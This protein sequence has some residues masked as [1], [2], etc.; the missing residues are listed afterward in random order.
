[1]RAVVEAGIDRFDSSGHTE[2]STQSVLG[3]QPKVFNDVGYVN[4]GNYST[5]TDALQNKN[6]NAYFNYTKDLGKFKI[7]A[8]A[9]YNYQLFQRER[10]QS[11]ETRQPNPNEDIAT[12]PDINLQSY[13]G[14]INLG[15]DSR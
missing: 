6:L 11:G 14:R 12:D 9:G 2:V 15:F 4:L 8:T 7:D 5:Y 3:F 10:Y 1:L 13:F